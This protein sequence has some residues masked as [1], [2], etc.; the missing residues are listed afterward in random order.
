MKFLKGKCLG[1]FDCYCTV[2]GEQ[3]VNFKVSFKETNKKNLIVTEG[4]DQRTESVNCKTFACYADKRSQREQFS[5]KPNSKWIRVA[6]INV[7]AK[8]VYSTQKHH[9]FPNSKHIFTRCVSLSQTVFT[10]KK[11]VGKPGNLFIFQ[12]GNSIDMRRLLCI[13]GNFV[14]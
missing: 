5:E 1:K 13:H 3:I 11:I 7:H 4:V 12:T 9:I 2:K 6:E 8:V 10:W 14:A